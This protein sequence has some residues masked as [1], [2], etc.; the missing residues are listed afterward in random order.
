MARFASAA[1]PAELVGVAAI[2]TSLAMNL[3]DGFRGDVVHDAVPAGSFVDDA[4]RNP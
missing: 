4:D 3:P 1:T 2:T